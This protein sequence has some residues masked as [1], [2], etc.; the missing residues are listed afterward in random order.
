M[1]KGDPARA[2]VAIVGA[3]AATPFPVDE[4]DR[5]EYIEALLEGG[6][7]LDAIYAMLR[8]GPPSPTRVN[9]R[10]LTRAL[11]EVGAGPVLETNA[12]PI[13]TRSLEALRRVDP[14]LRDQV[15]GYL[16]E[17]IDASELRVLIAHGAAAID[18]IASALEHPIGNV[19]ARD[20]DRPIRTRIA[21]LDVVVLSVPSLSPPP[22]N[23]WIP[24]RREWAG[25]IAIEAARELGTP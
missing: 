11:E 5:R 10:H 17:L 18:A 14:S 19:A 21:R 8:D 4:L 2:R 15:R 22:S 7:R 3:N 25:E 12:V 1:C 6:V 23:S 13:P 9:I 20:Y 16:P 24:R